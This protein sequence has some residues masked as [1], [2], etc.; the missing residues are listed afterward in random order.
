[1]IKNFD[2]LDR[3]TIY[4]S[5]H[6]TDDD[7]N[8]LTL[9]YAPLIESNAYKMYMTLYS[10][11]N[12]TSLNSQNLLHKE[13]LDILGL[14]PK[15]FKDARLRLE[16]IGLMSTYKND[17][18]YMFLLKSPLTAKGFLSDGVLGMYLYSLIGDSEFKRIQKLFLIPRVDKTNF[19]EITAS[20]DDVFKSVDE[21]EIKNDDYIVDRRINSGI[22]IKN[23]DF[24]FN[25]FQTGIAQSFLEGKR[26]TKRF[27]TFII[28]LAYAYGFNESEMQEIYNVSLNSSGHFDYMLCSKRSREKYASMHE[29]P[30]PRLA[31]KDDAK[32]SEE[33]ELFLSL[34]AKALIE[35]ATSASVATAMDI[36]KV[37]QLYQ[38]YN[39]LPRSVVNVCVIYAIKK[40]EGT[41]PAYNYFDTILKD[42][43]SKGINT[44]QLAQEEVSQKEKKSTK[45]VKKSQ[46]PTWLN[47]YVAK[48]EEGV[49]DL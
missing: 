46:N 45:R 16:A 38:E 18:E 15:S 5:A 28:N 4:A 42:W 32:M 12:R 21:I 20:F 8:V 36:D 2:M 29:A 31:V 33:E 35:A 22:K 25:L 11:L 19:V 41:V 27:E 7:V 43:I 26:I 34:S 9:L 23:Y 3:I 37:Q 17:N 44:F 24:D 39:V 14:N 13:L 47:E 48:F 30:L 10:I 40:C 6:L 49:E 1:M